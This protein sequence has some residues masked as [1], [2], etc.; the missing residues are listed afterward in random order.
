MMI[1]VELNGCQLISGERKFYTPQPFWPLTM[2]HIHFLVGTV[3]RTRQDLFSGLKN[4]PEY[5]DAL[6]GH[7]LNTGFAERGQFSC[8]GL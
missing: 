2:K 4:L 8:T 7:N 1:T 6:A 3:P 5:Y